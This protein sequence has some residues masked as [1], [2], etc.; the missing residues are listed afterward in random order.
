MMRAIR[1]TVAC[2]AVL[3]V[4]AGRVQAG[5]ITFDELISGTTYPNLVYPDVTFSDY[6]GGLKADSYSSYLFS[7][8]ISIWP[9]QPDVNGNRTIGYF[10][11][12]EM[13][14]FVSVAMWPTFDWYS[15]GGSI[16]YFKGYD[17]NGHLMGQAGGGGQPFIGTSESAFVYVEFYGEG[18]HNNN[19]HFDN[20]EYYVGMSEADVYE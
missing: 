12:D 19:F 8:P 16:N 17:I 18:G 14:N 10:T 7:P 1:L 11:I 13:V 20:F 9:K 15:N 3:V 2:L 5:F 4:T 6:D